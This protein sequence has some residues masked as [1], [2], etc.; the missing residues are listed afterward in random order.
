MLKYA[1]R[2]REMLADKVRMG[3]YRRAIRATV[4]KGD[5]V[6][7]IGTGSGILA[8]FALQAGAQM[9]FA[10][11]QGDVIEDAK[12][13]AKH[14]GLGDK[15]IFINKRSDTAKLPAKVDVITSE[16]IGYFGLEENLNKF[17]IDARRRFLKRGGRMIPAWLELYLAPVESGKLGNEFIDFWRKDFYGCDYSPVRKYAASQ[18]YV[19]DCSGKML[20]LSPASCV[21]H[22][23][24]YKID[25]VPAVFR[26]KFRA[27]RGGMFNGFVGFFKAGLTSGVVISTS[28]GKPLTHWKQVFF[29]LEGAVKIRKGDEIYCEVKAIPQRN[30]MFW[31]WNTRIDRNGIEIKKYSQSNLC[32]D[33][34]KILLK[35]ADFKPTLR[36]KGEFLS[37]VLGLCDGKRTMEC[38]SREIFET[39]PGKYEDIKDAVRDV[40]DI[41][42]RNVKL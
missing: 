24:Y 21:S 16:F 39:Y 4:K 19:T 7:D 29:P 26:K 13:I 36:A 17:L 30:N 38:I 40:V 28:P 3:S 8:Y 1:Y 15:I 37:R 22:I 31:E 12:R 41:I 20:F 5:I 32:I 14:N 35:K 42:S 6:C 27:A 10:I 9:V 34:K 2:H 25:K 33:R 18:R 23:D 11:E